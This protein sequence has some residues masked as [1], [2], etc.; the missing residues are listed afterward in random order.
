[1]NI[2]T[3]CTHI[4]SQLHDLI[5]QISDE[6][7]IKHGS[8]LSG[9]TIGQH[10][11]HTLEF[12]VMLENGV[13]AGIIN[14]DKRAHDKTVE[15]DKQ[16]ALTVVKQI[17]AFV[18]KQSENT[19]IVLEMGY[20]LSKEDVSIVETNY[21]RELVYNIEHAVHH[22]AI[23]KIGIMEIAPYI[24]LPRDFGVAAS[25]IRYQDSETLSH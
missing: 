9:S 17:Q 22:M 25:T 19:P 11:R 1:M 10:V 24:K 15:R 20:D 16:I 23:I 12:F 6:D 4:L 14:Y 5:N 21:L 2:N 3:A 13:R 18:N 7:F 8:T